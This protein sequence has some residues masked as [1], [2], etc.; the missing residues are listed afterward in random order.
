MVEMTDGQRPRLPWEA[1]GSQERPVLPTGALRRTSRLAGLPLRHLARTAAAASRLSKAATDQV[2]ARTA[3]QLFGTLG[4]LKGGAAKL[5]QAMSV[6]EAAM[7]EEVAAP[8]RAALRRLT[9]AQPAMPAEV[10]RR[11]V[12]ADLAGAYGPGWRERLV[13]FDAAPAAAASIGQVHRGRWRTGDG[14]VVDVAVKVQYPGVGKALRSDLRQARLL[15]RVIARFTGLNVSGLADEL[16]S[17]IVEELDYVREG[18]V[19]TEVAAAFT[20]RVPEAVAAARAAGVREPDGRTS[21]TVPSVY[22][23]T[24]RVLITG[25]LEGTSLSTLL[26]GRTDLLPAGWR[27]L[28]SDAADVAARLLGHAIYAPAACTG[29]MHADLHPGNFLL[30]PGGRLGML[31]FGAV[32][33]TPGGIPVPFGQLAVAVLAGD[34]PAAT[35]LARQVGAL[36]C[37]VEVDPRMIVELLHPV[38]ATAAADC[39]TYSRPWLRSLMA[40]LTQPRFAPTVRKLTPP[41]E[42]A[43]VWRATLAAAGLFAQ[44]GATVPTR[45]F[46]LAYSPGFRG[47][48]SPLAAAAQAISPPQ[49]TGI[50]QP[51]RAGTDAGQGQ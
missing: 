35:Q 20:R 18:R 17:R 5:G 24:P 1:A 32:A 31:D 37:D 34:G 28:G 42:Y 49:L 30:L 6:F 33:A 3:E 44:L 8:Y 41:P 43:L 50:R 10:A 26:D 45:G 29:W 46:H 9:D 36:A 23:A 27:E 16:A 21:I 22:A 4:E 12:A 25:W 51:V 14:R 39:F 48:A 38:V 47:G 13:A 19:Q 40:H 7:P 15:A 11:V 2:A